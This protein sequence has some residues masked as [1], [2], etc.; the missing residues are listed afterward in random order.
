MYSDSTDVCWFD[1]N[2]LSLLL[3]LHKG[4]V[5]PLEELCFVRW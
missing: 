5:F 1:T 3:L 2:K 4:L